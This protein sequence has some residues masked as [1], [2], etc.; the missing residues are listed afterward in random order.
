E[1][2]HSL[3][4]Q[5]I[6]F[7][8]KETDEE[9]KHFNFRNI[10]IL[11]YI[12]E[13]YKIDLFGIDL[14]YLVFSEASRRNTD[15]DSAK[16]EYMA[17]IDNIRKGI[18]RKKV[19]EDYPQYAEDIYK[20]AKAQGLPSV[21][22]KRV[23]LFALKLGI[24]DKIKKDINLITEIVKNKL[25]SDIMIE[26]DSKGERYVRLLIPKTVRDEIFKRDNNKCN[27]CEASD[28]LEVSHKKPVSKGGNNSPE[29]LITL[30]RRCN[31]EVGTQTII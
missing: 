11:D 3:I 28:Y 16:E 2:L 20:L 4:L 9:S 12:N 17:F 22:R 25:L 6:N 15:V 10:R 13:N 5:C 14:G 18:E 19:N 8:V 1:E 7:I 27:M 23:E 21:N 26:R 31:Q 30:C 24:I 29:N